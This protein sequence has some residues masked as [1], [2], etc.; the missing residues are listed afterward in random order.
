MI[1][2]MRVRTFAAIVFGVGA[3]VSGAIMVAT[4]DPLFNLI[5]ESVSS[6][7]FHNYYIM[8]LHGN[9]AVTGNTLMQV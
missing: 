2:K 1:C 6:C 9:T 8:P 7:R 5:F 4:F 3:I